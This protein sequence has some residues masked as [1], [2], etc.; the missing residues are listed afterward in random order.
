[1]QLTIYRFCS[2]SQ[3]DPNTEEAIRLQWV[4]AAPVV[5]Q[6]VGMGSERRFEIVQ[7]YPYAPAE[8]SPIEA[9]YIA[10]VEL[11]GSQIDPTEWSC[12][13]YRDMIP[14]ENVFV[15]LEAVGLPPLSYGMNCLNQPP[16]VRERLL[17]GVPVEEGSTRLNLVPRP[18]EVERVVAYGPIGESPYAAVYLSWCKVVE[19]SLF[20]A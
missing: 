12:W 5:G 10:L 15:H 14:E 3:Q 8:E 20:A 13:R 11:P 9:V 4:E 18:W 16:A 6:Q 7:V 17:A 1:M 2:E 19:K